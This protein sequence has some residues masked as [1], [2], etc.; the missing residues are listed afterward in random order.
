[1][2]S[3]HSATGKGD[4]AKASSKVAPAESREMVYGKAMSPLS[5]AHPLH[6]QSWTVLCKQGSSRQT[7][8]SPGLWWKQSQR[9][10]HKDPHNSTLLCISCRATKSPM[11]QSWGSSRASCYTHTVIT[12]PWQAV[13][14]ARVSASKGT[15]EWTCAWECCREG[16]SSNAHTI[17]LAPFT[18]SVSAAFLWK[19]RGKRQAQGQVL[20]F[21]FLIKRHL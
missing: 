10:E 16:A 8:G 18:L 14:P 17:L 1:M 15:H 11:R 13:E 4:W 19:S 7:R 9:W 3:A 20:K 2:H 12:G 6:P 21:V 5:T